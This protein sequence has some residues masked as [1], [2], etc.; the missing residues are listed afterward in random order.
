[1]GL[2][3]ESRRAFG[4]PGAS[5][6]LLHNTPPE[7]V[8]RLERFVVKNRELIVGFDEAV[9]HIRNDVHQPRIALSFDDGFA[10]NLKAGTM[11]ASHGISACFYVPTDVVGLS[12][13]EVDSFFRRPQAEGV[14][15]WD[16][17]EG[18]VD[19]GHAV[20][21]HCKQ[22]LPLIEMTEGEAEDQIK[23]SVEILRQRL[24]I[25]MHFAWPFGA[26][27]FADAGLVTKWCDEA[28]VLAASGVRGRNRKTLLER[29]HYLRRDAID[30]KWIN[31]DFRV[32]TA[33]PSL[34][35]AGAT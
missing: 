30:M 28:E 22:H 25:A 4:A 9:Q 15:T 3:G 8:R 19:A 32:F 16:D 6:L 21:S 20:G 35:G 26:I 29:E 1:M 2:T 5:V 14:A 13:P 23:G 12:K 10:S 17:L 33:R 27:A 7:S 31:T 24:G 34:G 18:L 11:L